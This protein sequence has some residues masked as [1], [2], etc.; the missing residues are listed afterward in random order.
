MEPAEQ[1]AR[2]EDGWSAAASSTPVPDAEAGGAA[3]AAEDAVRKS[4]AP[5]RA[6][7]DFALPVTRKISRLHRQRHRHRHSVSKTSTF[8]LKMLVCRSAI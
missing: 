7:L 1:P 8:S 5:G 2:C 6:S 4:L 3:G